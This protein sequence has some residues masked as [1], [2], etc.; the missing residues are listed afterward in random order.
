MS[1]Q[2]EVLKCP[3]RATIMTRSFGCAHAE[4]I[5]RR[6]GPDIA[7][8]SASSN[9]LCQ[10]FFNML[11]IPALDELGYEDDLTTMPAS[12]MQK[13]QF[14]GLLGLQQALSN[15]DKDSIDNVAQLMDDAYQ[16]FGGVGDFPFDACI[17]SIKNFKLRTRRGR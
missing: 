4:E 7:C 12:V 10:E 2:E 5:T 6:E 1:E 14:G 11:K 3:F 16:Q 13:I 17:E 15:I 9:A 8:N